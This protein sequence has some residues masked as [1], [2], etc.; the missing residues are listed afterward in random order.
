MAGPKK[1]R[2]SDDAF[3]AANQDDYRWY[4]VVG[5]KKRRLSDDAC[6]AANQDDYRR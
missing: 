6:L 2:L 5:P 1:R 3:L 4:V